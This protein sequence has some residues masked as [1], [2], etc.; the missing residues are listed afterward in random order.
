MIDDFQD[1]DPESNN[2]SAV[3]RERAAIVKLGFAGGE[4]GK[5]EE[6]KTHRLRIL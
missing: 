2:L 4:V 1:R 3:L 5:E 6:P